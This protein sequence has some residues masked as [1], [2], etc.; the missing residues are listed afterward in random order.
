MKIKELNLKALSDRVAAYRDAEGLSL[1]EAVLRLVELGLLEEETEEGPVNEAFLRSMGFRK[2]PTRGFWYCEGPVSVLVAQHLN[3]EIGD[4]WR[5]HIAGLQE[6]P[7]VWLDA[8]LVT[9]NAQK[10]DVRAMIEI[11]EADRERF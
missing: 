9:T 4:R 11:L 6:S 2:Y 1:S 3:D 8:P 10:V 5:L 7:E